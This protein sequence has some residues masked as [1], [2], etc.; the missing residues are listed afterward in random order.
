MT[1]FSAHH[2]RPIL[3]DWGNWDGHTSWEFWR[4]RELTPEQERLSTAVAC[5]AIYN[6]ETPSVVLAKNRQRGRF[7]I[8][9]GH[10]EE[11]ESILETLAREVYEEGGYK[12]AHAQ[13]FGHRRIVNHA[14][15]SENA[16]KNYPPIGFN[17]FFYAFTRDPLDEPMYSEE[18]VERRVC[19]LPEVEE[20][21][22]SKELKLGEFVIIK[23]GL[24]AAYQNA[25]YGS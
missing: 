15:S 22:Q 19:S 13:L 18:I 12:V 25:V 24:A 10:R 17:P 8:L 14:P 9:G 23:A 7:E 5:V 2:E 21:A 11:G 16:D 4:S 3:E 6:L 1:A 20:L